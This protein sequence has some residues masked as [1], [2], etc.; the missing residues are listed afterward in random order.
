MK[1]WYVI[2]KN[3]NAEMFQVHAI[4]KDYDVTARIL[5]LVLNEWVENHP[6]EFYELFR[7]KLQT[8]IDKIINGT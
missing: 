6:K 4:D 2:T 8:M 7:K 5:E 1:H 3:D